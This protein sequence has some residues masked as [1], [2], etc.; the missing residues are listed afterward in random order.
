MK[1]HPVIMR[2]LQGWIVLPIPFQFFP[3]NHPNGLEPLFMPYTGH[4]RNMVGKGSTK[5][6]QGILTLILGFQQIVFELS[7]FISWNEG[8]DGVFPFDKQG[9]LFFIKNGRL[10]F[11]IGCFQIGALSR[12][13]VDKAKGFSLGE[14]VHVLL[15]GI[16]FPFKTD[17]L[18]G[19][20]AI[21]IE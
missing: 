18:V 20:V 15:I 1:L 3:A 21:Q 11:L 14:I 5:G 16:R 13:V 17:V 9:H 12:Q 19:A 10:Y 2:Q 6:E 7:E 8:M 4:R